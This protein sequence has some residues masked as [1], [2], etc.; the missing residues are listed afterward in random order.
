MGDNF[1]HKHDLKLEKYR[2]KYDKHI[3]SYQ[4]EK[5]SGDPTVLLVW[6][7]PEYPMLDRISE[8]CGGCWLTHEKHLEKE[9]A[10]I[11]FDN[12]RYKDALKHGFGGG[13]PDF[14]NRNLDKQ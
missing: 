9:A 14:A 3:K 11:I 5:K 4:T 7:S 6:W 13:L 10:G 2:K 8:E 1:L 12:T